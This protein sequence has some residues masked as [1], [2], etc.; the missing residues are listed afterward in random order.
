MDNPVEQWHFEW[1]V[2]DGLV[3]VSRDAVEYFQV[4]KG[5]HEDGECDVDGH[6]E[7]V[8]LDDVDKGVEGGVESSASPEVEQGSQYQH[9]D[10]HEHRRVLDARVQ[11]MG[12]PSLIVLV[13]QFREFSLR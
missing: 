13:H 11:L 10:S 9:E 2:S 3:L 6:E 5:T 7:E 4:D 12:T 8:E 1:F